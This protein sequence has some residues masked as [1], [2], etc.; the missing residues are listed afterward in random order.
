MNVKGH[1]QVFI[2]QSICMWNFE[3]IIIPGASIILLRFM[4]ATSPSNVFY[5]YVAHDHRYH[6]HWDRFRKRPVNWTYRS[7]RETKIVGWLSQ[8]QLNLMKIY[9]GHEAACHSWIKR[10]WIFLNEQPREE[11]QTRREE[12]SMPGYRKWSQMEMYLDAHWTKCCDADEG[13][14]SVKQFRSE[15]MW[16]WA[17]KRKRGKMHAYIE[18]TL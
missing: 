7:R 5:V 9:S 8:L 6:S 14:V 15:G 2:L 1:I 16:K 13:E 11:W 4:D 18:H 17:K 12:V 10:S 3:S